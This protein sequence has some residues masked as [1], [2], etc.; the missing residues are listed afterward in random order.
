ML[1]NLRNALMTGKRLPTAKDYVQ[2]GLVAMWDGIENAGWG[3]HD[4]NA[5]VWTELVGLPFVSCN[6]PMRDHT[7]L[8]NGV[9][10]ESH[11]PM[12]KRPADPYAFMAAISEGYTMQLAVSMSNENMSGGFAGLNANGFYFSAAVDSYGQ[13][14]IFSTYTPKI[15][16]AVRN[17]PQFT[18]LSIVADSVDNYTDYLY[19]NTVWFSTQSFSIFSADNTYYPAIGINSSGRV[20][21][22]YA[23]G[24]GNGVIYH[25]FRIY[26]RALTADEIARNYK[27]DKARFGLP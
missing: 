14:L 13:L 16:S 7:I 20:S 10:C 8:D 17:I 5:T 4:A 26:S 12:A 27:I 1:I 21:D 2:S 23:V 18:T 25:S 9:L 15:Y 6:L 11:L 19:G 22:T 24:V 3:V